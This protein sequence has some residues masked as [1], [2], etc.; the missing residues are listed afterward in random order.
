MSMNNADNIF[1]ADRASW[2]A[3]GLNSAAALQLADLAAQLVE[4]GVIA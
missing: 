2:M 3:L 1:T 4:R